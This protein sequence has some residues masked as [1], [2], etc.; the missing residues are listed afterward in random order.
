MRTCGA[1]FAAVAFC[2]CVAPISGT[3]SPSAA[4]ECEART[5]IG[6]KHD[7]EQHQAGGPGLA[8]PVVVG[9]DGVVVDHAGERGDGL[10]PAG[11]PE[12][13]AEGGEEQRSGFA[14]DARE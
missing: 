10:A 13:I 8:V 5:Y 2:P 12:A 9:S 11:A 3:P 1:S 4:A 7:A 6:N 14:G